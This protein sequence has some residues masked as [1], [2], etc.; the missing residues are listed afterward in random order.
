MN[1]KNNCRK[2]QSQYQMEQA[3]VEL[4][5]GAEIKDISVTDIGRIAKVNRSTFYANY[6]D[7]F[8]LVEKTGEKMVHDFME[9]YHDEITNKFNSNNYLKLF[10]HIKE[11]QIFYKTY[12]KLKLM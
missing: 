4:L 12:F 9:L 8:D 7:I 5:Q 11:N 6:I 1:T 2:K 3:L 10:V